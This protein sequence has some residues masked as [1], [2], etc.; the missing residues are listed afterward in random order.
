MSGSGGGQL[1]ILSPSP[2]LPLLLSLKCENQ[3]SKKYFLGHLGVPVGEASALG[4]DYDLRVM[5]SNPV[6]SSLQWG[7]RF[8]LC[9]SPGLCALSCLLSLKKKFFLFHCIRG[10]QLHIFFLYVFVFNYRCVC[11]E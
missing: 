11:V 1:E 2:S 6:S 8:A 7:V 5:G 4:S 3:A 10:T 9:P